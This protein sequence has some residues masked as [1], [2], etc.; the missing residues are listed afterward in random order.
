MHVKKGDTVKILTGKDKGKTGKILKCLREKDR[1]IVE[2][3]NV[4]KKHVRPRR[5]GEKGEIIEFNASIHV[6]N[7]KKTT[8]EKKKES[9]TKTAKDKK[10]G[11][12]KK[13]S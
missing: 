2:G 6:S 4:F 10:E 11:R 7:V 1:V 5:D 3:A 13:N 8:E 12:K 9:S